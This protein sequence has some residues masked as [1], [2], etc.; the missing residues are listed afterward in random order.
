MAFKQRIAIR[1]LQMKLNWALKV[2]RS[3]NLLCFAFN[4]PHWC[5][6]VC[7]KK[8]LVGPNKL[9]QAWELEMSMLT[10]FWPVCAQCL[11]KLGNFF[12]LKSFSNILQ[13]S[14]IK[15]AFKCRG[16]CTC[17]KLAQVV[18]NSYLNQAVKHIQIILKRC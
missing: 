1:E 17:C 2:Q 11:I 6:C 10:Q 18:Q 8:F 5:F 16:Y 3:R 14:L 9:V 15:Y 7:K 13:S 12:F 4:I